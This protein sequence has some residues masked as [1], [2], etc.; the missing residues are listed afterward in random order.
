MLLEYIQTPLATPLQIFVDDY[1]S[2]AIT[3]S[4][5]RKKVE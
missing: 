3:E 5:Q 4:I 2:F 1:S